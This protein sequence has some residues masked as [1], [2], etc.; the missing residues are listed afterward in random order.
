MNEIQ[1]YV[2]PTSLAEALNAIAHGAATVLAGGTDLMPQSTAGR[3]VFRPALVNIRRVSE[4]QKVE[5][6]DRHVRIGA[7]T[8]INELRHSPSIAQALP[9]LADAAD[10]F[11]SDQI[12]NMA[13][14]GGNIANASPAGDTLV[15]LIALD[16]EVELA[17]ATDR[18]RVPITE[19]FT[20]PGR[21]V[22]QREE[23][24]VA[25]M[26]PLPQ[27]GTVSRFIK[28]GTRPA[29]DIAAV[30]LAFSAVKN[31]PHVTNVRVAFGAVAPVPFRGRLTE[32]VLEGQALDESVLKAAAE[33]AKAE[34][35]PIDDVR[36]SAWYRRE[37]TH[38]LLLKVLR[39]VANS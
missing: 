21:T 17:S 33:T 3:I 15:P 37:L 35:K 28:F 36:A 20:G 27:S 6:G 16:A 5:F 9:L 11:A 19:F 14:L 12:R 7:L 4:L 24:I 1:T 38:A 34:I 29:L 13:T 18:R 2:A 31:G 23:L 25:V 30:S 26:V 22:L 10:C 8:T 32:A 39:Y